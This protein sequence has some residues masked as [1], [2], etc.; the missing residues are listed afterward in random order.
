MKFE[1]I[2]LGQ[3]TF[4]FKDSTRIGLYRLNRH[5]VILIDS[6]KNSKTGMKILNEINKNGWTLKAIYLTHSHADHMGGCNYLKTMTNCEVYAPEIEKQL[7]TAPE[8][9]PGFMYGGFPPVELCMPFLC[10][11]PCKSNYLTKEVLPNGLESFPLKG[12]TFNMVGYKT[13]DNIYFLA[14]SFVGCEVLGKHPIS[15]VYDVKSY[16][17]TLDWL[18]SLDGKI[19][20]AAHD[21]PLTDLTD[22]VG[23]NREKVT[24]VIKT[25]EELLAHKSYCFDELLA[26][27]FTRFNLVMNF[28]QHY[29][30]GCSIKS[31]LIFLRRMGRIDTKV[32]DNQL[33]WYKI[34]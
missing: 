20:L 21:N 3:N 5:E 26:L 13:P 8:I 27:I 18:E 31:Y 1:L 16:L 6:G 14:D 23:E 4:Y 12:H 19:Y 33:K 22:I 9:E 17:L 7:T 11:E 10:A 34:K 25:I 29:L 24:L 28:V 2:Q 15:F 30:V 32:V